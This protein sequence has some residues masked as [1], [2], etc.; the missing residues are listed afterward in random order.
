MPYLITVFVLLLAMS[1]VAYQFRLGWL[2]IIP[3]AI[4]FGSVSY[5]LAGIGI[6]RYTG[7]GRFY[8]IPFGYDRV[9]DSDIILSVICW[10][11]SWA[12]LMY[13]VSRLRSR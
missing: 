1:A 13:V 5:F 12:A 9:R 8:S 11:A 4:V 2:V 7:V 10:I 3:A 6:P